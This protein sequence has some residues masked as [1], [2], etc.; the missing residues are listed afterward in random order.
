MNKD[1]QINIAQNIINNLKILV[2]QVNR[3]CNMRCIFCCN[4]DGNKSISIPIEKVK[5]L[6]KTFP[7]LEELILTG[8]ESFIY[9]DYVFEIIEFTKKFNKKINIQ[10]NTTGI[11][12]TD[13]ILKRLK[14]SV[15]V[16]HISVNTLK[17]TI[18]R[19]L[20]GANPIYIN[21][22]N[23]NIKKYVAAKFQV[24]IDNVVS[25][26]NAGEVLDIYKKCEQWGVSE[27]AV[28]QLIVNGRATKDMMVQYP[29]FKK[30]IT[31]LIA[32]H[33]K[34]VK[35][36]SKMHL[37][38]W[39]FY[40]EKLRYYRN[41]ILNLKVPNTATT[42]CC[43]GSSMLYI[44]AEGYVMPCSLGFDHNDFADCSILE[45]KLSEIL[46]QKPIFRLINT[47]VPRCHD[48]GVCKLFNKKIKGTF[49]D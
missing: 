5:Q 43:C 28:S 12:L 1:R 47:N 40:S 21:V 23:K 22:I 7:N 14:K 48:N 29:V 8:G 33:K 44:S 27:Y 38:V 41:L 10:V 9:I 6:I 46:N 35:A 32:H 45:K 42:V 25:K 24:I 2:I 26:Y 15:N 11:I 18:F 16:V 49:Y 3:Q 36:G 20:K 4:E 37:E 34:R 17:P 19:H 13:K 39:C 31:S 30:M